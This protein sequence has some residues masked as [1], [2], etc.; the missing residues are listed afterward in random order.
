MGRNFNGKRVLVTGGRGF[1]GRYVVQRFEA[2]GAEVLAPNS[3]ILNL[4]SE[5]E[6]QAWLMANRPQWV[7]HCAVE[8]GGIGYMRAHPG[9]IVQRNLAM[10]SAILH[11][12][13]TSGAE[14]FVGVSSVCAYPRNATMP[15]CETEL[16]SGYPE[17]SN[18]GY[19]LTK[20]MMME[21]G[22][23]YT[24]EYGFRTLFPMPV[25]LYGPGDDFSLERSHVVPA[26]I[27]RFLKAKADNVQEVVIWGT[28]QATREL[29]YVEDCAEAVFAMA[30][31]GE[32]VEPVNIGTG[33]EISIGDLA[34]T[35]AKACDY[36][37]ALV[38]DSSKPEGQPRK[39]LD[40]SRAKKR[41]NWT[42]EVSWLEGLRRTVAWY[43][44]Q[45]SS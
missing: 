37:G 7:V 39:C 5:Q 2:A 43:R 10:N 17:P 29:L 12:A 16:F 3:A 34:R 9:R 15:L 6:T 27:R 19:G 38:F 31:H 40:V 21:M 1:L 33:V 14:G 18:A 11:G 41:L 8:G 4:C 23:A 25:N 28:G 36:S 26:L 20:R 44:S 13:Y 32:D 22:R 24:Q 45:P 30:V 42:A 35:I